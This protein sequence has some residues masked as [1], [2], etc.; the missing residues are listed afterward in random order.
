MKRCFMHDEKKTIG[1]KTMMQKKIALVVD[2]QS[3][4]W[5]LLETMEEELLLLSQSLLRADS[6]TFLLLLQRAK[7]VPMM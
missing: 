4:S 7:P 5:R 2:F 3:C 1:K 6:G